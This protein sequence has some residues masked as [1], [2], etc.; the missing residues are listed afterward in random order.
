MKIINIY[1]DIYYST[2]TQVEGNPLAETPS[3]DIL[4]C[5][6]KV[7]FDDNDEY[8]QKDIFSRCDST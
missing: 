6:A 2:L 7:T 3:G 1:N 5:D 8:H 4:V